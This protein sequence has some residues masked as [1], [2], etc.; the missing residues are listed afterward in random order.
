MPTP[1][2]ETRT[3]DS[4]CRGCLLG[5][6]REQGTSVK[7]RDGPA[8]V[9]DGSCLRIANVFHLAFRTAPLNDHSFC[10]CFSDARRFVGPFIA[11]KREGERSVIHRESEDLPRIGCK[12]R[13]CVGDDCAAFLG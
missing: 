8:A 2:W 5:R 7:F 9:F 11:P 1:R 13:L 4:R 12:Q 10:H 6:P 3:N